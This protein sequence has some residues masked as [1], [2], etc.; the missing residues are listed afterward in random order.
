MTSKMTSEQ[1]PA[2]NPLFDEE[3]TALRLQVSALEHH[4]RCYL[5][6]KTDVFLEGRRIEESSSMVK[7]LLS[8][9]LALQLFTLLFLVFY[10]YG[11]I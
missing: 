8:T 10:F 3:S 7:P 4:M 6:T 2:T 5:A 1:Q 11:V 9:I